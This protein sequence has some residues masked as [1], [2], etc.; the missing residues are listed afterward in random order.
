MK[1][2]P[3]HIATAA[4]GCAVLSVPMAAQAGG[5][6]AGTVIRNT[7]EASY[8][9]GAVTQQVSSNTVSITVDE[10]LDL[11]VTSLDGAAVPLDANGAVLSF[12][13]QNAGNG[14]EAFR[15]EVDPALTGDD[16]DPSVTSIAYDSNGNGVYDPGV[17]TIIPAGGVTPVLDPDETLRLFVITGLSGNPTDGQTANVRFTGTAATGSGTPGT[18]FAGQGEGGGN[19]VVGPNTAS[20]H[21]QGTL[22]AFISEVSLVKSYSVSDP[23][24]GAL[25]VSGA[26]VT[27]TLVARVGGSA[28]ASALVVDDVIPAGTHYSAGTLTLDAAALTD[29]SGDDAGQADSNAISVDL[30]TVTG[31]TTHTI[32]FKVIVD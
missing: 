16:F 19:A 17:D 25:P 24:G 29:A 26:I 6:A 22:T 31:G 8:S 21:A 27:Y 30:G 9:N 3:F 11:S 28:S 15:V 14:P 1:Y 32:A 10:V 12:Q 18:G 2:A 23:Y 4:L 13:I 5:I 7:A 20:A